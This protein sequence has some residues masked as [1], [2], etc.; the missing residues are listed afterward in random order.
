[1]PETNAFSYF[2][3]L[4]PGDHVGLAGEDRR[5]EPRD[6][7]R[8][9]LQVG[10]IEHEHVAAR[11]QV[12]GAQRVGDAAARAVAHGAQERVPR[13]ASSCEHAPTCRRRSRRR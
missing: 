3:C 6:V 1:M 8:L 7:L 9:E 10:G 12:A 2:P 13:R 5:D 4:K 11:V